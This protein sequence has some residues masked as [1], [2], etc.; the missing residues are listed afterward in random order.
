MRCNFGRLLYKVI[1]RHLPELVIL[2]E[3]RKN[4]VVG[5]V[6]TIFLVAHSSERGLIAKWVHT[7]DDPRVSCVSERINLA[8]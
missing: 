3:R 5:I 2:V 6:Q 1:E 8:A 7:V 4:R